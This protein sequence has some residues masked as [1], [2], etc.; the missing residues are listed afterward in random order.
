MTIK[1]LRQ[2]LFNCKNQEAEVHIVIGDE[3]SD[4]IDTTLFKIFS[5]HSEDNY[6]DLFIHLDNVPE[7]QQ[8][9]KD[10]DDRHN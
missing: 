6:Q 5:D 9:F 8:M 10:E 4:I 2:E 3:D 1:E 7:L